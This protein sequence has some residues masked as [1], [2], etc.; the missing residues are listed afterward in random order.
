[1]TTMAATVP[2]SIRIDS[3]VKD[4]LNRIAQSQ[5]RSAHALA[6]EAVTQLV[7]AQEKLLAWNQSC[8]DSFDEYKETSLHV[9]SEEVDRWMDSWGTENELPPPQCHT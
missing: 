9:T 6:S 1:M 7:E 5:K 8:I 3:G 4:R 2:M